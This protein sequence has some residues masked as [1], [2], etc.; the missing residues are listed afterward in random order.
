MKMTGKRVLFVLTF[1]LMFGLVLQQCWQSRSPSEKW[2]YFFGDAGRDYAGVALG[3]GRGTSVPVPDALSG[4]NVVVHENH[5]TYSP[6]QDP[7]LVLSF[8]P[9][10][11][12]SVDEIQGRRWRPLG[13][14]WYVLE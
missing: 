7:G 9:V 10:G 12:P 11:P 1:I 13:D 6:R 8:S 2:L 5:V 14:G 3:A 4:S